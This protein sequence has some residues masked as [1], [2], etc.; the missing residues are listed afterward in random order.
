MTVY[1]LSYESEQVRKTN[2][3]VFDTMDKARAYKI[4]YELDAEEE[5]S[6]IPTII[7]EELVLL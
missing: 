6:E 2:I 1:L 3:A 5:G 4:G 7:I